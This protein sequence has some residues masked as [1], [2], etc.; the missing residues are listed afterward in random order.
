MRISAYKWLWQV[1]RQQKKE[2]ICLDGSEE[3]LVSFSVLQGRSFTVAGG[4]GVAGGGEKEE[5]IE[6]ARREEKTGK[7]M[8]SFQICI[9]ISFSSRNEIHIYL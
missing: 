9:L 2:Q 4:G 5:E 7:K 6:A 3:R 1:S 8:V